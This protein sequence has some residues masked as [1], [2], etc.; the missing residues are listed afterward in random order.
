MKAL[1]DKGAELNA[2]D[3]QGNT[4]LIMGVKSGSISGV[5]FLL[6][7]GAR[8]DLRNKEGESPLKQ[9]RSLHENKRIYNADLVKARIIDLLL[10]ANAKE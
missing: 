5:E 3:D 7:K 1:L 8:T 9:A 6:G 2:Q 4:A 10:K